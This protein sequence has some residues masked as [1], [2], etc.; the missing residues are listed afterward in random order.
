MYD[1]N[2]Y[3]P[4]SGRKIREDGSV[5]NLAQAFDPTNEMFKVSSMQKKWRDS[6]GGSSL[7]TDKWDSGIGTGGSI[8]VSG[9]TL[10]LGS[11]I[12]V[13]SQTYVLSKEMFTVPF[14]LSVGFTLSQRIV[15]QTFYVEAVS[16]DPVTKMPD[17]KHCA[18]FLF[19]G[20]TATQAKYR[21]QN[22][23]VTPLDSGLVTVVTTGG[24][25]YYEVEPFGDEC[26]FHSGTLDST[27]GRSNSYRR[28]Q[29]IPDPNAL[30]K[31][32]LRWCNSASAPAT[33]T[34]AVVQYIAC[35]DY[36]ELTAEITSGR[37][38]AVAGQGI[39]ATVGGTVGV[40]GT[41]TVVGSTAHDG[42]GSAVNP[43]K[44]GGTA[45]NVNPAVVSTTGDITNLIATMLG[46]QITKPYS[47]PEAEFSFSCSA[48]IV[49]T[50]DVVIKAA[51]AAGIR[52]YITSFQIHNTHATVATEVVLK[53]GTTVIWRGYA[54]A[55]MPKPITIT[56]NNPLKGTAAV[57][58]NFACITT[59]AN[60]YVN[61]QG[62]QAP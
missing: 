36:A 60:V 58:L 42:V 37:G 3:S 39:Y 59:G 47:I 55:N 38:N 29:Q 45:V 1:I 11:G 48:A 43:V 18:S 56:L 31:I 22:S 14:K 52:N 40:S 6:F 7:N 21:V 13:N 35:Q 32:R 34:T 23:G 19:D 10:I 57:A 12:A 50:T 8:S 33:N 4:G 2:R 16:V 44:I 25:A 46:V 62:Y 26:W 49:N 17:G 24:G 51:G 30:Y 15:N 20:T 54:P 61:A 28:H 53:D 41:P 5:V 27:S 9:G